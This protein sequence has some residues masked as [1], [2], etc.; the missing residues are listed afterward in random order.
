[1]GRSS[2][3]QA[4]ENRA[5]IVQVASDLFRARGVEAVGIADVMKAAGLTQG[6]FYRHF[7]SKDALAAEA[8]ALAFANAVESWRSVAREAAREGRSAAAAIAEHYAA[9]RPPNRTC[10]MIA[11]APDAARRDSDDPVQR[12]FREGVRTLFE[13][14]AE[15][16]GG[17]GTAE[18]EERLQ[19]LFA[20]MVGSTLLARATQRP[21]WAERDA[22]PTT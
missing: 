9:V 5:R 8:C 13:T 16:A 7:P 12:S 18:A 6:G 20:A 4:D 17:D 2:R 14:F 11:F 21:A 19:G 3:A 15:G 10:P 22:A 1:M